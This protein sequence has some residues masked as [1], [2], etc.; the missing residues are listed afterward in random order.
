MTA[1][2]SEEETKQKNEEPPQLEQK[3][4]VEYSENVDSLQ[5]IVN[6]AKIERLK[7]CE[8]CIQAYEYYKSKKK[9]LINC[10]L[11]SK[12]VVVTVSD[13]KPI[14]FTNPVDE[15]IQ[16]TVTVT[17]DD[18]TVTIEDYDTCHEFYDANPNQP[19]VYPQW[20]YCTPCAG[21]VMIRWYSPLAFV[22]GDEASDELDK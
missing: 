7:G 19:G 5:L 3:I 9:T 8:S 2:Q 4:S 20:H 12:G 15:K 14:I 17:W 6:D 10:D 18:E 22:S 11:Y 21:G 1:C 13:E 16:Q